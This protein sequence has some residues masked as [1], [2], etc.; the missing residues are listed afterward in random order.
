MKR[1]ALALAVVLTVASFGTAP[2]NKIIDDQNFDFTA[3]QSLVGQGDWLQHRTETDPLIQVVP[4]ALTFGG[5]GIP[6]TSGNSVQLI[7]NGLAA[8][9]Q[10][11]RIVFPGSFDPTPADGRSYYYSLLLEWDGTAPGDASTY[12]GGFIGS[13]S[14][15][16]TVIRGLIRVIGDGADVRLGVQLGPTLAEHDTIDVGSN[17]PVNQPVFVVLKVTEVAGVRNDVAEIFYF[18]SGAVPASEPAATATS[19]YN[20]SG[21]ANQD[22]SETAGAGG[23]QQFVFRQFRPGSGNY[24]GNFKVDALRI[25]TTWEAVT[26]ASSNSNDWTLY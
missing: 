16:S 9:G 11:A 20:G 22:I 7:T 14:D 23:L 25:G 10:A 21:S 26:T 2:A 15:T 5:T 3:A 19:Q 12:L 24:P 13:S 18:P 17:L 4:G 6:A 1:Y 8:S